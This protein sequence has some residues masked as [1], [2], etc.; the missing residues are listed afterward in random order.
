MEGRR[1]AY[2]REFDGEKFYD[3]ATMVGTSGSVGVFRGWKLWGNVC[4][5]MN[6]FRRK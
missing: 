1:H 2:S 4:L 5:I 6:L 3:Y